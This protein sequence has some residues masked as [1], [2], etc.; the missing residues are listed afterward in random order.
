MN[1]NTNN[2]NISFLIKNLNPQDPDFIPKV[3]NVLNIIKNSSKS[4]KTKLKKLLRQYFNEVDWEIFKIFPMTEDTNIYTINNEYIILE[5][6]IPNFYFSRFINNRIAIIGL[7]NSNYKLFINILDRNIENRGD[8]GFDKHSYEISNISE[9]RGIRI[10]T[11]GDLIFHVSDFK[12]NEIHDYVSSVIFRQIARE[13][14]VHLARKIID[15]LRMFFNNLRISIRDINVYICDHDR[16]CL[17]ITFM[18]TKTKKAREIALAFQ[19][20]LAKVHENLAT[21]YREIASNEQSFAMRNW[22]S[23]TLLYEFSYTIWLSKDILKEIIKFDNIFREFLESVDYYTVNYGNHVIKYYGLP[24]TFNININANEITFV[25]N[26]NLVT[27]A[28]EVFIVAHPGE[29]L[30][31]HNEHGETILRNN[32]ILLIFLDTTAVSRVDSFTRNRIILS[33]IY[34]GL[35]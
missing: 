14:N 15:N 21:M 18:T 8:L 29:I 35:T 33:K 34:K 27:F 28:E 25:T 5:Y 26:V 6:K 19:R 20:I 24:N 3:Y 31:S 4:Q 23:Q 1:T 12:I 7:D 2:N 9:Y 16:I 17:R 11:Q 30:I 32:D 10:R 13:Y 22:D